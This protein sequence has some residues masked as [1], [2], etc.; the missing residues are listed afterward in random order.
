MTICRSE[1][2]ASGEALPHPLP[3]AGGERL[4]ANTG[5]KHAPP[6]GE[7]QVDH[8]PGM[9]ETMRGIVSLKLGRGRAGAF[10]TRTDWRNAA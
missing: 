2:L 10:L 4:W 3:P 9:I 8:A 7:F 1:F 6:A 5:P